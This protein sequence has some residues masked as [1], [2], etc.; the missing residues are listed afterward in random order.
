MD[1][2]HP[3]GPNPPKPGRARVLAG[4]GRWRVPGTVDL[5]DPPAAALEY[6]EIG[7]LA[8]SAPG[9]DGHDR[10]WD[11]HAAKL[12]MHTELGK[13]SEAET[14]C[15]DGAR[16][17]AYPLIREV[18]ASE[19]VHGETISATAEYHKTVANEGFHLGALPTAKPGP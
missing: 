12:A 17:P 16:T 1:V 15:N 3:F 6:D 4:L 19:F 9:D 13:A 7:L 18:E 2:L 8:G 11:L 14:I 10:V 5:Q